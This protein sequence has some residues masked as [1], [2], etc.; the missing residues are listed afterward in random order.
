MSQDIISFTLDGESVTAKK[1]E[2]I[3]QVAQRYGET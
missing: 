2:T 1:G 3:W